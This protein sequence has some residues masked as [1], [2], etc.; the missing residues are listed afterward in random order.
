MGTISKNPLVA[1]KKKVRYQIKKM[2]EE[3][4]RA[5]YLMGNVGR[6]V[7]MTDR[8]YTIEADGSY[9]RVETKQQIKDN[10]RQAKKNRKN[11]EN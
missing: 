1:F 8:S 6:V 7:K 11:N 5:S 4:I 2:R 10:K 3:H 9:K